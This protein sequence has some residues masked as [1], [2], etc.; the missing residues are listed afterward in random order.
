M[1]TFQ[2]LHILIF[3]IVAESLATFYY[4]VTLQGHTLVKSR[5][6]ILEDL[7]CSFP[8]SSTHKKVGKC[9]ILGRCA[10]NAYLIE[11]EPGP[12]GLPNS[13]LFTIIIT[14]IY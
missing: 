6:Y 8:L 2:L 4:E 5:D 11:N 3:E 7:Y 10:I 14:T 12:V 13:G 9:K 1:F